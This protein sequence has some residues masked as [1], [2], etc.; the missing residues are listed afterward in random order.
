[1]NLAVRIR[2]RLPA[3][4]LDV[5]FEIGP[6]VTIVFGESGSGK[7]TL[8]RCVAGLTKPDGGRIATAEH[9]WFD[10]DG[11]IDVEPRDRNV[12]FFRI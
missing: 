8:L 12:R 1:M 5:A 11:G 6:G 9:V 7:T 2:K 3:F 4:S 10:S